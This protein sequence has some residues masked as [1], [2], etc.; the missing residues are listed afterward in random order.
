MYYIGLLLNI[1]ALFI[2]SGAVINTA[3]TGGSVAWYEGLDN[4]VS[5]SYLQYLP[6]VWSLAVLS[7]L[8]LV[9]NGKASAFCIENGF[10][11]L[12][13]LSVFS[14]IGSDHFI[15]SLRLVIQVYLFICLNRY[16][17]RSYDNSFCLKALEIYLFLVM[18]LSMF[19]VFFLP[20]YGVSKDLDLISRWQGVFDQ[21]NMLGLVSLLA[22]VFFAYKF[23]YKT[24]SKAYLVFSLLSLVLVYQ[25][26]STTSLTLALVSIGLIFSSRDI[27][28]RIRV[29]T[30]IFAFSIP[31]LVMY[32]ALSGD[33]FPILG[34]DTS[35]SGRDLIWLFSFE[36]FDI[37]SLYG[38][39]LG[40]FADTISKD[41]YVMRSI[42]GFSVYSPHSGYIDILISLG[43]LG[44]LIFLYYL[45]FFVRT[46]GV[47]SFIFAINLIVIN[48]FETQL[49]GFNI[50]FLV[51]VI[52]FYADRA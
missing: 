20:D 52:Y 15:Y 22:T 37:F 29:W 43:V 28:K 38:S 11:I 12:C 13:V 5:S 34:K 30:A 7:L 1:V 16:F 24:D 35:F 26:G 27:E 10:I 44:F 49:F 21:K 50:F 14:S 47:L 6:H 32:L 3:M 48:S 23:S 17:S 51:G 45:F 25:S 18:F 39:G 19:Y 9:K 4:V 36:K 8:L 31:I 41:P 40:H 46:G 2:A 33:V 42:I